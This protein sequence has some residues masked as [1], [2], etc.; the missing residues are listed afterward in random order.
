M[1]E[2]YVEKKQNG[3]PVI[4]F[5][6]FMENKVGRLLEIIKLLGDHNIHVMAMTTQ[7]TTD[8]AILRMIVDDPEGARNLMLEHAIAHTE[9]EVLVVELSGPMEVSQL[10]CVILQ[11]E[12]NVH[13]TYSF[14]NR[15]EGRGAIVIHLEDIELA[16][17]ALIQHS[18]RV[19]KQSDISR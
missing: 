1:S 10:L 19:L 9:T 2:T 7:D 13:Y 3:D 18:A 15:P 17:Q 5:S 16:T 12:I 14:I 8:S 11:A 6:V 4:Q